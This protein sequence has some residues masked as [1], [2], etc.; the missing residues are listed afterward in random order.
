VHEPVPPDARIVGVEPEASDDWV[1][2]L[3]EGRR[4][5]GVSAPQTIADALQMTTPGEADLRGEPKAARRRGD[6]Q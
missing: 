2:S 5:R 3:E 4:V 1:R 6:R